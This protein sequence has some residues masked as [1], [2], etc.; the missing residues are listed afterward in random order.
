MKKNNPKIK[1][2]ITLI[3]KI[4]AIEGITSS[5][6]TNGDYTPYYSEISEITA[7]ATY[8]IEGLE[9]EDGESIY[10][11][12]IADEEVME[13]I[14]MFFSNKS[15]AGK[16]MNYVKEQVKDKVDF[17]KKQLIHSHSDMNK[18][19]DFCNVVIDSFENFSKLNLSQI[20]NE[21]LYVGLNVMRQLSEKNFTKDDL[22]DVI[23]KAAH[24]DLDK[25][26][27]EII[28]A[29]NAEIRELK[30]YKTLWKTRN[31]VSD[32]NIIAMPTLE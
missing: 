29:K 20:S 8:F 19:I 6:F 11:S 16:V 24:F 27:A 17:I 3:D 21:D 32:N 18:I 4:S 5:Y 1:E 26:S 28:D 22:T 13:L 25:A 15:N 12:V 7:I 31:S 30:K 10:N 9:F 14:Q 23:K 2:N